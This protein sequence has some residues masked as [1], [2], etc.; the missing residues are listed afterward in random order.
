MGAR[1]C[2]ETSET[3]DSI[4]CSTETSICSQEQAL[5]TSF[6]GE[7]WIA[8]SLVK[9]LCFMWMVSSDLGA[10]IVDGVL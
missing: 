8:T 4:E 10:I 1:I 7:H 2:R 3:W 6:T 5:L 9:S